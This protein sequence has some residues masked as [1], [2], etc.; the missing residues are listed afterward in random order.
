MPAEAV[1]PPEEEWDEEEHEHKDDVVE[2]EEPIHVLDPV[3]ETARCI[4]C[5]ASYFVG[6]MWCACGS[7]CRDLSDEQ[8][9]INMYGLTLRTGQVF[10][11]DPYMRGSHAQWT[12]YL[13]KERNAKTRK[14]SSAVDW[15]MKDGVFLLVQLENPAM[16]PWYTHSMQLIWRAKSPNQK[17]DAVL[18]HYDQL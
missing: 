8:L 18:E 7:P 15:A 12:N 1:E 2:D 16:R 14:H 10:D 6:A 4:A 9:A 13:S 3:L 17:Q 5:G 11:T